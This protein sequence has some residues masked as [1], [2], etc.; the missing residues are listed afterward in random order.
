MAPES[1]FKDWGRDVMLA[2]A[3]LQAN[4]DRNQAQVRG[5]QMQSVGYGRE[6]LRQ[7]QQAQ[8]SSDPQRQ[9]IAVNDMRGAVIVADERTL[10]DLHRR[11]RSALGRTSG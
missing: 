10:A 8:A 4:L 3:N 7:R 5:Y 11:G 6:A 1:S 2:G 9:A